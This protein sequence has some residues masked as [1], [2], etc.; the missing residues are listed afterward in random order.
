[1]PN[2]DKC[3]GKVLIYTRKMPDSLGLVDNLQSLGY[4]V[5]TMEVEP[6]LWQST[7]A[8]PW[9]EPKQCVQDG[10]QLTQGS[11][12]GTIVWRGTCEKSGLSRI[13]S[14]TADTTSIEL[15]DSSQKPWRGSPS[16][17]SPSISTESGGRSMSPFQKFKSYYKSTILSL[18]NFHHRVEIIAFLALLLSLAALALTTIH[19]LS[20]R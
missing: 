4:T 11:S 1:M 3:S 9:P 17:P 12:R 16:P 10:S 8:C 19:L 5:Q 6:G 14:D 13:A 7:A 15:R 18:G 20:S 2:S